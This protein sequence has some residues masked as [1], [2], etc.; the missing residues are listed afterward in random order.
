M[1]RVSGLAN[2]LAQLDRDIADLQRVRSYLVQTS[3][4]PTETAPKPTRGRKPK[5]KKAE[6]A[7]GNF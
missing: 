6:T 2:I 7:E 4:A 5:A 3:P 1:A